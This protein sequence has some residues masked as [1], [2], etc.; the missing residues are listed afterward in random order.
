MDNV[1]SVFL[2][3]TFGVIISRL[4]RVRSACILLVMCRSHR[5]GNLVGQVSHRKW[6]RGHLWY[7]KQ[8]L[9]HFWKEITQPMLR[10]SN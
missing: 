3:S 6:T 9:Q 7:E 2:N 1:N 10:L 5:V 8:N 4:G